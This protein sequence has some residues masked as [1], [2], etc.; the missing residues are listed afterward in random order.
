ML[1]IDE[2]CLLRGHASDE[3]QDK[4]YD[5]FFRLAGAAT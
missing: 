4:Q 3:K 5:L 2:T 1:R